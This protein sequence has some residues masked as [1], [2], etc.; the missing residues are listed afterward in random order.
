MTSEM[1]S[2]HNKPT[3]KDSALGL[4]V[5][6]KKSDNVFGGVKKTHILPIRSGE[7]VLQKS[8]SLTRPHNAHHNNTT[9]HNTTQ[10]NTTQHN[11]TQHNTT[12]HNTTQHNTT[13]HNTTQ[14]NTTQHNTT[15]NNNNKTQHNTTQHQHTN[16]TQHTTPQHTTTTQQ[17]NK[18]T[19]PQHH[20][21]TPTQHNTNLSQTPCVIYAEFLAFGPTV[22]HR[23]QWQCWEAETPELPLTRCRRCT[24]TLIQTVQRFC[25]RSS[26]DSLHEQPTRSF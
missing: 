5:F 25:Q 11:T 8:A 20:T 13:Q 18:T 9:Q 19:T 1:C 22:V 21:N 15:Q 26:L 23:G 2:F 17:D 10:H 7:F 14:H 12:Q 3:T 4:T 24:L 16:T 6:P